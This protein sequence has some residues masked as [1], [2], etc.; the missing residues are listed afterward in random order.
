M[1][2]DMDLIRAILLAIE[3]H[4]L[5]EIDGYLEI[6]DYEDSVVHH[7]LHLLKEAGY[8]NAYSA[9][10]AN[11]DSGFLVQDASLTW[12]GHE[13]LDSIRDP[14]IWKKAKSGAAQAGSFSLSLIGEVARGFIKMKAQE[15]GLPI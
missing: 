15:I 13:L 7:H 10:D 11:A 1:K 2:R 12:G 3:A 5:P 4:P 14:E 6:D 8:I 9:V